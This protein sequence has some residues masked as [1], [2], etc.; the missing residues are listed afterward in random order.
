MV[1]GTKPLNIK[2]AEEFCDQ[3]PTIP[4]FIKEKV[5]A[6]YY[7][8]MYQIESVEFDSQLLKESEKLYGGELNRIIYLKE[9]GEEDI[10]EDSDFTVTGIEGHKRLVTHLARERDVGLAETKKDSILREKE[11]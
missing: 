9:V 10:F 1:V 8:G 4:I 3:R 5:N 7:Q 2:R 11:N 6:W